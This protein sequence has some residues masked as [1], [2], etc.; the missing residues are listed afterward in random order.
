M[1][2]VFDAAAFIV[3]IAG[4]MSAMKLQKI[5][6]YCQAW[7]LVWDDEPLFGERIEAWA[8]GPVVPEL[9]SQHKGVFWVSAMPQGNPDNLSQDQKDTIVAVLSF[10][11]HRSAQYL[12]DLT[13]M[14]DPWKFAR[15][16]LAPNMRGTNEI[17]LDSLS[18]YYGSLPPH[19]ETS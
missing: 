15:G 14:E 7:A 10:Y 16:G 13:H 5:I 2:N 18:E 8:N 11:G 19:A 12:S 1:V 3:Q 6:F 17:S 4:R 9:Y